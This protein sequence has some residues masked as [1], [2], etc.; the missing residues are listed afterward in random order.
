[1]TTSGVA[2][3]WGE[4]DRGQ[5][6]DGTI[7]GRDSPVAVSGGLE[8]ESIAAGG[9]HTCGLTTDG[10]VRCWGANF[11]GQLGDG[12]TSDRLTPVPVLEPAM[13]RYR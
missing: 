12:S 1:M 2:L 10:A 4:N 13:A 3:C 7:E 5:L 11:Y 6:G 9:S 8:F